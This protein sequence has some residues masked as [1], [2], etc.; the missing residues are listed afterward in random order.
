MTR[1]KMSTDYIVSSLKTLFGTNV[2]AADIKGWCAANGANYQTVTNKIEEFKVSR[3][4]WNL[5]VTQ[6]RVEEIE[7]TFQSPAALPDLHHKTLFLIKMIPSSSLVTLT[8]LK[9]LFSPV[10]FTLRLSRVFRVMVKRS[11]SNKRVLNLS[12]NL[13]E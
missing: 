11:V 9:K 1:T 8:I 3:G 13:F 10:S 7:R 5:E 2:T 6:Q 12:V 4:R